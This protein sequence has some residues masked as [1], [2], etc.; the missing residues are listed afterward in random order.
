MKYPYDLLETKLYFNQNVC[1]C[2]YYFKLSVYERKV[3]LS[4]ERFQQKY[5]AE[6][7]LGPWKLVKNDIYILSITMR[8]GVTALFACVRWA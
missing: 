4:L 5:I 6:S 1:Y 2:C 8:Y 7:L 3:Q